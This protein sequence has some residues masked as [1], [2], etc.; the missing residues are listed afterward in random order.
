MKRSFVGLIACVSL[1]VVGFGC[2][3]IG[4]NPAY[5]GKAGPSPT[6][7]IEELAIPVSHALIP[8]SEEC[9]EKRPA[10]KEEEDQADPIDLIPDASGMREVPAS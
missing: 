4:M 7:E 5:V 2:F 3:L 10:T 6:N 9:L 1:L 8:D